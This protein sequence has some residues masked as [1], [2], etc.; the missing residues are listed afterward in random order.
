MAAFSQWSYALA[1]ALFGAI[2]IWQA[3]RSFSDSRNRMLVAALAVTGLSVLTAAMT[4]AV[5]VATLSV[6]HGRDLVWLGFLYLIWRTG[7]RDDRPVTV[8][9][10]YAVLCGLIVAGFGV[11]LFLSVSR[12]PD[13]EVESVF[14]AMTLVR[15]MTMV[16][17]MLLI[18]NLY[19]A[20]SRE[21]R[22]AL[23]LPLLGIA[24][25]WFYDLNLFT[26]SYLSQSWSQELLDLRGFAFML[27]TPA[28]A[29]SAQQNRPWTLRLSRTMAFQSVSLIAIGGY[30]AMMFVL[31]IAIKLIGGETGRLAQISFVFVGLL[32]ALILL[33]SSRFKAWFRVKVSKHLFQHRYDYRAEWLRFTN[34]LGKPGSAAETLDV[35]VIQ[36]IA[37]IVETGAGILMVPDGQGNLLTQARWNWQ[38]A[39]P[40]AVGGQATLGA[41]FGKTRRVIELD[42]VRQ[43]PDDDEEAGLVPEWAIAENQAW[44]MVPLVHFDQ[45]AGVIVLS[46]PQMNR[47]LDWEDFDVLRVA[48]TQVASYLAEARGQEALSDARRFD[49]FNRR[50]AFIMHD[51][52]NLVSQLSLLTRNAERHADN[53]EFRADMI[54]TLKN[55]TARMNALLARLSQHNKGKRE[56]PNRIE[57]GLIAERIAG[58][59]RLG[60]PIIIA[61][62]LQ[63]PAVVEA[64]RLEQALGHLVQNAIDASPE[65]EPVTLRLVDG[66]EGPMIEVIDRGIGMSANFIETSLFKPFASTKEGGFGIGAFEAK[67]IVDEMGGRIR[68]TSRVN[69]GTTFS[70]ILPAA[71]SPAPHHHIKAL[72]A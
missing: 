67:A 14:V 50:F 52:K 26:I 10:L 68:V 4:G 5:S 28:F 1:A 16:G 38:W 21:T 48:G 69:M 49:E 39:D 22:F 23:R 42:A 34:T 7:N 3:Q 53:P 24:A 40:P 54:E 43:A 2:A 9:A 46:R 35:R 57:L 62:D 72:A 66:D 29:L 61:G 17:G 6:G 63:L 41:H 47:M 64:A 71:Q 27:A 70:L 59:K 56:E 11:D 18:H 13:L 51:I 31:T 8:G 45:L 37:D 15:M 36:A 58:A 32:A 65:N 60:H 20:A 25:L 30:L 55:S 12:V 33:P 44:V 19:S